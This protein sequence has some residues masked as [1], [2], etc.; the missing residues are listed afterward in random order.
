MVF[1]IYEHVKKKEELFVDI[2]YVQVQTV[3]AP[4]RSGAPLAGPA[5]APL[6]PLLP[7][8][9]YFIHSC[10]L[11]YVIHYFCIWFN[12]VLLFAFS[13]FILLVVGGG[14]WWLVVDKY[15]R[16]IIQGFCFLDRA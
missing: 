7:L 11:P 10:S 3:G 8:L 6:L 12:I 4:G 14:G 2:S 1:C 15:F 13:T 5:R 16:G 9:W